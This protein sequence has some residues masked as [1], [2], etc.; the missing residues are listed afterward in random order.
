MP[1]TRQKT[2]KLF[3]KIVPA[4]P[5]GAGEGR[6]ARLGEGAGVVVDLEVE[7]AAVAVE[8]ESEPVAVVE[9]AL[10]ARAQAGFVEAREREVL[11]VVAE[12]G[13]AVGV[14]AAPEVRG[15]AVLLV[16]DP[17]VAAEAVFAVA[18]GEVDA[19][20]PV[21]VVTRGMQT[22]VARVQRHGRQDTE[23][24]AI[25][26]SRRFWVPSEAGMSGLQT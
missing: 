3:E 2:W 18:P 25:I 19:L 10:W 8:H 16:A 20:L 24:D 22:L 14:H 26:R 13:P 15:A 21:D 23:L 1:R 6:G 17:V 11:A 9:E 7:P 12:P 5:V 4:D